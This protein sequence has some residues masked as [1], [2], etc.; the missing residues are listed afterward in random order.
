MDNL[1]EY[2]KAIVNATVCNGIQKQVEAFRSGFKKVRRAF[3]L[4]TFFLYRFLRLLES[5]LLLYTF[6]GIPS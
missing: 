1:E 3:S 4:A 6:S 2:I 5:F